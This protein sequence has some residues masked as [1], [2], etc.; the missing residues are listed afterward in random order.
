MPDLTK[1]LDLTPVSVEFDPAKITL[2]PLIEPEVDQLIFQT[3]TFLRDLDV[4]EQTITDLTTPAGMQAG[5]PNFGDLYQDLRP[6]LTSK[7]DALGEVMKLEQNLREQGLFLRPEDKLGISTV[8]E[9]FANDRPKKFNIPGLAEAKE[10]WD[11]VARSVGTTA[12]SLVSDAVVPVGLGLALLD[13]IARIDT[14]GKLLLLTDANQTA[15]QL[16]DVYERALPAVVLDDGREFSTG[17]SAAIDQTMQAM[18]GGFEANI[19]PLLPRALATGAGLV[20][21]DEASELLDDIAARTEARGKERRQGVKQEIPG[22]IAGIAHIPFLE[23]AERSWPEED[24]DSYYMHLNDNGRYVEMAA[25]ATFFAIGDLVAVPSLFIGATI[26]KAIPAGQAVGRSVLR[27]TKP[28]KAV[29]VAARIARRN[30]TLDEAL[31]GVKEARLALQK[32]EGEIAVTLEGNQAEFGSRMV[33]L[34]LYK[35][36]VAAQEALIRERQF[37]AQFKAVDVPDEVIFQQAAKRHP[38]MMVDMKTTH[39][40]LGFDKDAGPL[41][42]KDQKRQL[43]TQMA[44]ERSDLVKKTLTADRKSLPMVERRL[45]AMDAEIA[46]VQKAKTTPLVQKNLWEI[47]AE[48][49]AERVKVANMETLNNR[50]WDTYGKKTVVGW[51]NR[52]IFGPDDAEQSGDAIYAA[53]RT[54]GVGIDDVALTTLPSNVELIN[55]KA[56]DVVGDILDT[57]KGI[58]ELAK[59]QNYDLFLSTRRTLARTEDIARRRLGAA[60]RVGDKPVI[61]SMTKDLDSVRKLQKDLDG[62][63]RKDA[64]TYD[65]IWLHKESE[66]IMDSPERYNNWLAVAG[67]RV[68]ESLYPGGLIYI[69]GM[70]RIYQLFAPLREPQRFLGKYSPETWDRLRSAYWQHDEMLQSFQ[71]KSRD[72]MIDAGVMVKRSKFNPKKE[73][74]PYTVDEVQNELLFNLLDMDDSLPAWRELAEDASPG[75][76]RAHHILRNMLEESATMQGIGGKNQAKYVSGYVKHVFTRS[77]MANGARPLEFVGLPARAEVFASHLIN[78]RGGVDYPRDAVAAFEVYGRASTR[79]IVLEPMYEDLL[80]S[81]K[82]MARDFQNPTFQTYMTDLVSQLKGQPMMVGK[83]LD[84]WIGGAMNKNGQVLWKPDELD[85]KIMGLSTLVYTNL[86]G[87][88]SRYG[89]MQIAAGITT[90]AG[91]FGMGRTLKGIMAMGTKEGQALAKQAGVYQAYADI[92]EGDALKRW[93]TFVTKRG[94]TV[95]PGGVMSNAMAEEYVRGLTFN[96]AIEA[97]L[98]KFGFSKW[99]EAVAAGMDR[100]VMFNGLRRS[101]EINHMFGAKGRAPW[102]TRTLGGSQGLAMSATQFLSYIPKQTEELLSQFAKNPGNLAVYMSASGYI[103]RIAAQHQGIDVTDYVGLGYLPKSATDITSPAVDLLISGLEL[104]EAMESYNP[105]EVARVAENYTKLLGRVLVPGILQMEQAGKG[106]QRLTSQQDRRS[107]GELVRDLAIPKEAGTLKGIGQ[108]FSDPEKFSEMV[109]GGDPSGLG[110]E[111]LPAI[112]R[113]RSIRGTIAR[114]STDAIRRTDQ[115]KLF[116]MR[117]GVRKFIQAAEDND[118]RGQ[119]EAAQELAEKGILLKGSTIEKAMQARHFDERLRFMLRDPDRAAAYW[120][121][122]EESGIGIE[123]VIE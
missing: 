79:K 120:K 58:V 89:P 4:D 14:G 88:N 123:G 43:I 108:I 24:V 109:T 27:T 99:S 111:A 71:N 64:M 83:K 112:F 105:N 55:W 15:E 17:F 116:N 113:Q 68:A 9:A 10:T 76:L 62:G 38:N 115:R 94:Y 40:N 84:E 26:G 47:S 35:R 46:K 18:W 11:K 97:E 122:I 42:P 53:M 34:D 90:T 63:L 61:E 100:R 29:A 101:E 1:G 41:L 28:D 98:T 102:L 72:A 25:V 69:N 22:L 59:S 50:N 106:V 56:V 19:S 78:R 16:D 118:V 73:F 82:E 91:R 54:A 51:Q 49:H 20:G 52:L 6:I 13:G 92:F 36:N 77:V 117:K 30:Y 23:V 32:V 107:S 39:R 60:R 48:V 75:M 67:D 3:Q 74:N 57:E 44:K 114:R 86:L 95:T 8:L 12:G 37:A 33:P 119:E 80:I 5:R 31:D 121:I 65:D 81:G 21:D 85:R 66:G 45:A 7:S 96:A 110:G 104:N 2:P 70:D 93:S 103:A 87:G